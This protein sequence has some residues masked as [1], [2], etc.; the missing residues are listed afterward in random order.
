MLA[1]WVRPEDIPRVLVLQRDMLQLSLKDCGTVIKK[2]LSRSLKY[3][4]KSYKEQTGQGS[5][6]A[7]INIAINFEEL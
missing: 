4:A 7:S 2:L 1:F 6:N 3:N 5:L